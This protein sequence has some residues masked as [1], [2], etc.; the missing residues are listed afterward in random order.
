M[1]GKR[2]LLAPIAGAALV[3]VAAPAGAKPPV[4][5]CPPAFQGAFTAAQVIEMWP[6]AASLEG[7][8]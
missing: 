4:A 2:A 6:P 7:R 3:L 8:L 1:K 5:K